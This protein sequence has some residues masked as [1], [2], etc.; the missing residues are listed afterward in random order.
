MRTTMQDNLIQP[1]PAGSAAE[2]EQA[3]ER[4]HTV[5][6]K[7]DELSLQT[8]LTLIQDTSEAESKAGTSRYATVLAT[9]GEQLMV[10]SGAY[11]LQTQQRVQQIAL[12][13]PRCRAS[14]N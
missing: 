3:L 12:D 1:L 7:W 4:Y 14:A 8:M 2:F 13:G 5:M 10:R 11:L 9:F 6:R